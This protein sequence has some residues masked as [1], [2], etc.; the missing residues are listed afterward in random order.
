MLAEPILATPAASDRVTEALRRYLERARLAEVY[1]G[2]ARNALAEAAFQIEG[3]RELVAAFPGTDEE[4][5]QAGGEL[6][7]L[8]GSLTG[9]TQSAPG[10]KAARSAGRT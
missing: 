5:R 4:K 3:I 7:D 8:A 1:L 10:W 6:G 9:L 2:Q